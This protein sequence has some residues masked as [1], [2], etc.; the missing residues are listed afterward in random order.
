MML[1]VWILAAVGLFS[2]AC[3]LGVLYLGSLCEREGVTI[4]VV[5]EPRVRGSPPLNGICS[6]EPID[7]P[8]GSI[9]WDEMV[10]DSRGAKE[11]EAR[12]EQQQ[13]HVIRGSQAELPA[14]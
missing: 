7:A 5:P 2:A 8:L 11:L 1:V 10:V 6:D 14:P 9:A 3:L 4:M 13:C 12:W